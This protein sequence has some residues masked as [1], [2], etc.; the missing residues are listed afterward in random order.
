MRNLTPLALED[1]QVYD[2]VV[3]AKRN[4]TRSR[5]RSVRSS[6]LQACQAYAA[7][8]PAVDSLAAAVLSDNERKALI[9]AYEVPTRPMTELRAALLSPVDAARCPFCGIGES[10][11]LDHYL[12]KEDYP[13][14][15]IYSLNLVPSCGRCNTLKRRLVVDDGTNVRRFLHLYFDIIPAQ[16]FLHLAVTVSGET[17]GLTYRVERPV[18]LPYSAYLQIE[19]HFRLLR[20]ADR[21]RIMSL[22]ELRGRYAALLRLYGAGENAG[23]VKAMLTDEADTLTAAYGVNHWRAVMYAGLGAHETFCDGG[24]RVIGTAG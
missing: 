15:S 9:H 24:F 21:Y 17:I 8:A 20:L 14:F 4:P 16:R 6:V 13:T 23:R 2:S 12:P 3:A 19:S 11:T 5:L 7:A 1:D 10:A 22:D 18:G